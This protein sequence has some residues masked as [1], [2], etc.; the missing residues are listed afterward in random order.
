MSMKN[1]KK[2]GH[3]ISKSAKVCPNCGHK[4]GIPTFIKVIIILVIIFGCI[5]G[6]VSSCSKAV[7]DSINES[8][9]GY[10]DQKGKTSFN[11][12]ETFQSKYLKVTFDSSNLNFTNYNKYATVKDGYKVVEFKFTAENIGDSDQTFNYVDFNC[13]ADGSTMQQFYSVEDAGLDGGGTISAGKKVSIPVYCEV[14]KSASK[15]TVEYKPFLADKNYEFI[16]K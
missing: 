5:V 12:G 6:C 16:A 11:V 4:Y 14:P 2:C 13:Y 15:V 1:C 3:Q 9:G 7:S 8:L 10:D